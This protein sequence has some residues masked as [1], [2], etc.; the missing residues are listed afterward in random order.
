MKT[1]IELI[2][3]ERKRQIEVKGWSNLNDDQY[4]SNELIDGAS[5]HL[6]HAKESNWCADHCSDW[7]NTTR[8]L[9]PPGKWPWARNWWKPNTSDPIR[10][11]VKAGALIAAEIDRLQRKGES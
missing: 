3:E 2:S 10:D 5:C 1:G 9:S 7:P 11:L 4:V 6:D 8:R